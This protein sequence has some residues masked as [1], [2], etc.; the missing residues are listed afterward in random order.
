MDY[1]SL[2]LLQLGLAC[3]WVDMEEFLVACLVEDTKGQVVGQQKYLRDR[4]GVERG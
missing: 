3:L 1:V 2:Q 4:N